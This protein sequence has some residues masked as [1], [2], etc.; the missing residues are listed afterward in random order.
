MSIET[1]Q[2]HGNRNSDFGLPQ[3]EF[4]P[5]PQRGGGGLRTAVILLLII[6]AVGGGGAYWFFYHTP[7]SSSEEAYLDIQQATVADVEDEHLSSATTPVETKKDNGVQYSFGDSTDTFKKTE[8]KKTTAYPSTKRPKG[9]I[10]KISAPQGCYYIVVGSFIDGDLASDHATQLAKKGIDAI[11]L[12]PERKN[13]F[14]RVAIV[15]ADTLY[16][17]HEGIEKF[18]SVHGNRIWV[19]KY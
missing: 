11:I 19:K 2:P 1:N 16:T 10:T 9:T 14:S 6:M 8:R 7:A 5:L 17:A 4:R 15:Q 12:A 3:A 18:K 13:D